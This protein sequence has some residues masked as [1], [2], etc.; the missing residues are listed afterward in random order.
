MLHTIPP[1]TAIRIYDQDNN[2]AMQTNTR[3]KG[4][5]FTQR[6]RTKAHL[7]LGLSFFTSHETFES[8]LNLHSRGRDLW[9]CQVN[10]YLL[11]FLLLSIIILGNSGSLGLFILLVT[12]VTFSRVY[13]ATELDQLEFHKQGGVAREG[14]SSPQMY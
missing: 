8:C 4:Q 2:P 12:M 13:I 1:N 14:R 11:L 7:G 10:I 3:A 5:E 9:V 6:T